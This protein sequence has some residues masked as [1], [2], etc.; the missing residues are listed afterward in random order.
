MLDPLADLLRSIRLTSGVFFDASLAAPWCIDP[1]I[2]ARARKTPWPRPPAH[3]IAY[4]M[5]IAGKMLVAVEGEPAMEVCAG[6]I[7]LLPRNDVHLLASGAGLRPTSAHDL[8]Q[9]PD[10]GGLPRLCG[11]D[12]GE[13]TQLM[14]GFL[15]S[16]DADNP[17]IASLPRLLKIAMPTAAARKW[18]ETTIRF[19][20]GESPAAMSRLAELLL[21]DAINRHAQTL[22]PE[23]AGWLK[24][25]RDPQV[26][27]ALA[28]MHRDIGAPWSAVSLARKVA[29]SRSA[30]TDR[31]TALVGLSPI[32]Y[33]TVWRLQTA[34]TRLREQAKS[35][36]ELAYSV[37]YASEEAFSRAFKREFGLSPGRWRDQQS[38]LLA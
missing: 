13:D 33:L 14:C 3:I 24:G 12:G 32:R 7:V 37:G 16:D 36:S 23:Q 8:L 27:R 17:L 5:V 38:Q 21:V 18:I 26:G 25:M 28:L 19:A 30:F 20:A 22:S 15:G 4:H 34:K 31:F 10:D 29:L 9:R 6:E 1:S 35:I 11:R 2:P